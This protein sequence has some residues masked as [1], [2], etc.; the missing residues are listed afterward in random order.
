LTAASV[1]GGSLLNAAFVGA[2]TVYG[3]RAV[4]ALASFACLS[5]DT[6][7]ENCGS[8]A[9]V[10]VMFCVCAAGFAEAD[11]TNDTAAAAMLAS[12]RSVRD[13]YASLSR[14]RIELV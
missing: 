6:S 7:V 14:F 11:P 10:F 3:P 1:A 8:D 2:K 4:R 13:T 9:A 12:T 5:S